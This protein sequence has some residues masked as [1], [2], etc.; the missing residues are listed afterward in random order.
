MAIVD[1]VDRIWR[2]AGGI[3][4]AARRD[5]VGQGSVSAAVLFQRACLN[6]AATLCTSATGEKATCSMASLPASILEKSRM[7]LMMVSRLSAELFRGGH[8]FALAAVEPGFSAAARSSPGCRASEC[9][10][11]G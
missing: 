7:S 6:S 8:V 2:D 10:F 4:Q 5:L 1:Q 3:T 11:H 9:G